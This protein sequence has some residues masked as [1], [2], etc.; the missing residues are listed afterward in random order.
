LGADQFLLRN[1]FAEK[2]FQLDDSWHTFATFAK[3]SH[4]RLEVDGDSTSISATETA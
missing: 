3:G 4:I 2:P 1:T